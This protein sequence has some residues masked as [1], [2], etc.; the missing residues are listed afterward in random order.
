MEGLIVVK[1]EYD[2][3]IED[4]QRLRT[5]LA[6]LIAERDELVNHVCREIQADYD[7]KIGVLELQAKDAE[8]QILMLKRMIELLQA[9]INHGKKP[10]LRN[11]EKQVTEEFREY[12][13]KINEKAEEI[14]QARAYADKRKKT[15]KN[16]PA[17]MDGPYSDIEDQEQ[18]LT[19]DDLAELKKL[20]RQIVKNLHP[21]INPDITDEEK[22]LLRQAAEA[23]RGGDL[24]TLRKLYD[25]IQSQG[26]LREMFENNEKGIT[27]L[28]E[29]R[30]GLVARIEEV[31]K[32]IRKIKRSFPYNERKHLADEKWVEARQ[33]ELM[34]YIAACQKQA[35]VL[36]ERLKVL[37][38]QAI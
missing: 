26:N 17:S 38:S 22:E 33:E 32:E 20:Y 19:D 35:D 24:H 34:D 21:D 9:E 14:R 13:D 29:I 37:Q 12:Q 7:E 4:I 3:L 15:R 8:N 6:E 11:A 5:R 18:A 2:E 10:S 25:I 1:S 23:Y 27:R 31:K 30:N 16:L 28:R 36:Q